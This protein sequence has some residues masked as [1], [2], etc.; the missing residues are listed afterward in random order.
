M[1]TS[2]DNT[3]SPRVQQAQR[4]DFAE[5]LS[6]AIGKS[7]AE[8]QER[9]R[10]DKAKAEAEDL[11]DRQVKNR[12]TDLLQKKEARRLARQKTGRPPQKLSWKRHGLA[13]IAAALRGDE[14]LLAERFGCKRHEWPADERL[15][16]KAAMAE[17]SGTGGGY[18]VPTPMA[19]TVLGPFLQRSLF[20]ANGALQ[21]ATR[22]RSAYVPYPDVTTTPAAGVP[23]WGGGLNFLWTGEAKTRTET[24]PKFKQVELTK[25][26]LSGYIVVSAPLYGDGLAFQAVLAALVGQAVQWIEDYAFFQGNGVGQPQGIFTAPATTQLTR[27]T[28]GTV[29]YLDVATMLAKLPV[30]SLG[31]AVWAFNPTALPKLL[32]LTDGTNRAVF[33]NTGNT[34]QGERPQWSLAGL[35]AFP[36]DTV[37]VMGAKG[38][39]CLIDPRYYAIHDHGGAPGGTVEIIASKEINVLQ[40]QVVVR[41]IRRTDGQPLIEKPITLGDGTTQVSP[42]VVLN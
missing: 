34:R 22:A 35:P 6:Q 30:G 37:P 9:E 16:I 29:T 39:L 40:N 2:S 32:Q 21:I 36:T 5:Q 33:F 10:L 12:V 26:E 20:R 13:F 14:K 19:R 7:I 25:A 3:P 17:S 24:E 42:F 27:Q 18:A 15:S 4:D 8:K 11:H 28:G 1:Q 23:P 38:D 31:S 41:V